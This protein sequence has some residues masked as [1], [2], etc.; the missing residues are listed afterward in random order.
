[1]IVSSVLIIRWKKHAEIA[2]ILAMILTGIAM[3]AECLTGRK[4]TGNLNR[5]KCVRKCLTNQRMCDI[6]KSVFDRC[7]S[8]GD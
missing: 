2:F 7:F 4:W 8:D 6:M 5:M 1:M 3:F